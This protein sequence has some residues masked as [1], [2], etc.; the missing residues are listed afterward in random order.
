MSR[1]YPHHYER[2]EE[3]MKRRQLF[4]N[5]I[6]LDNSYIGS[7]WLEKETADCLV[8]TLGI[9]ICSGAYRSKGIGEYSVDQAI[10]AAG[11]FLEIKKAELRVRVNNERAIRCYQKCGFTE[12]RRFIKNNTISVIQMEKILDEN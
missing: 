1:I 8:A 6:V 11:S 3:L 4:W 7:V 12:S 2:F 10:K 9:F 5:Y